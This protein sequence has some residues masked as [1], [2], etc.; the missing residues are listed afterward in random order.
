MDLGR[1]SLNSMTVPR[2]DLEG[3]LDVAAAHGIGHVAPWR[4]LLSSYDAAVAGRLI[5]ERGL[6]LS[7]LC[8]GGL[9]TAAD[10]SDRKQAVE[11]NLRAIDEAAALG[12]PVLVLV[13]GGVVERS[14]HDSYQMVRDGIGAILDHARQAGVRLGIEPLHP[15]MAL[16]RSVVTRIDDAL[17]IIDE[18]GWP[19][20]LGVVVD[21]YHVWWDLGLE[22]QL[23]RAAG[24]ILG[25]H[26]SD[27]VSPL[28]GGL[29][30]GR[31][32]MG[33]GCIDLARLGAKLA[34][35]GYTGPV[36]V[37]VIS[38]DLGSIDPVQVVSTVVQRFQELLP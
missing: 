7:S 16:D 37:E 14:V 33:D 9:F 10:A 13:C 36:E 12:A 18:L 29:T 28:T 24:R 8:R 32:M 17:R 20:A 15:M 3:L 22:E 30:S 2:L 26:V 31:G 19:E 34:Q 27:W 5:A 21:A 25:F 35:L 11:D 23:D 38:D 1:C 4:H 6:L